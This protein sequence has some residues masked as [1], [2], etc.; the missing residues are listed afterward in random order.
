MA[1]KRSDSKYLR[2]ASMLRQRISAGEITGGLPGVRQLANEYGVNFMTVNKAIKELED[3]GLVERIARKGT[4]VSHHRSVALYFNDPNPQILMAPVYTKLIFYMQK[5]FSQHQC[6]MFFVNSTSELTVNDAM[7]ANKVDGIALLINEDFSLPEAYSKIP[8]VRI[9]GALGDKP[10]QWDHITYDSHG[11]GQVAAEHLIKRNHKN[12]AYIG[13]R[14]GRLFSVW[15]DAFS[16]TAKSLG[17]NVFFAAESQ[18]QELSVP[19]QLKMALAQPV[20]PT[21]I[22]CTTDGYAAQAYNILLENGVK[23][24]E[25]I[26]VVGCNDDSCFLNIMTPRPA[27]VDLCVKEIA[28]EGAGRLIKRI[29]APDRERCIKIFQ[30]KIITA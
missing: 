26:E 16:N 24:G 10:P 5:V 20:R 2:I 22:F 18:G 9:M 11:V 30:P 17:G 4:F 7:L 14:K 19:E 3:E 29:L 25:D 13:S 1:G 15:A 23:P 6:S 28:A 27:T 8:C 21:G 12:L